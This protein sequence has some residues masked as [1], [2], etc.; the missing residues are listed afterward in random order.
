[1]QSRADQGGLLRSWSPF[2]CHM[3]VQTIS[4]GSLLGGA[5][6]VLLYL[7]PSQGCIVLSFIAAEDSRLI[8]VSRAGH[9][10]SVTAWPPTSLSLSAVFGPSVPDSVCCDLK[11][12]TNN[13]RPW[14]STSRPS[15]SGVLRSSR[16]CQRQEGLALR[17]T[18]HLGP[19]D[20]LQAKR[21]GVRT[22]SHLC[23]GNQRAASA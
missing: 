13:R 3:S 2:E 22:F 23:A 17:R 6:Q 1:M 21:E 9:Y 12:S 16:S 14:R 18:S 10:H 19:V 15:I 5:L 20:Y 8:C 4:Q 11:S 7:F